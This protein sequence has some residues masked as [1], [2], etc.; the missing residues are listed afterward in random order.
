ML[1]DVMDQ[2][3][4][5][6][7]WKK[8]AYWSFPRGKINKDEKDLDCAIRE[9]YEETGFDIK[10]ADL[11][12]REEE[13]KFIEVTMREQH[14]RLY[15]FRGVPV[16]TY[17]EPRTRKEISKIQWYKLSEL[18]TLT[19]QKQQQEGR[20]EDL[21]VNANKFYMVA[22]FLGP[23]KKWIAQQSKQDALKG[24]DEYSPPTEIA[25]EPTLEEPLAPG[26]HSEPPVAGD[27]DRLLAHLRQSS[28]RQAPSNLPELSGFNGSSNEASLQLKRLL[29]VK[30]A[31]PPANT[32]VIQVHDDARDQDV[33]KSK[34]LLA[35]LRGEATTKVM[36]Q[37]QGKEAPQTPLEQIKADTTLSESPHQHHPRP[38]Q[39]SSLPP[40]PSFASTPHRID[41][42]YVA[43]SREQGTKSYDAN[44]PE[45]SNHGHKSSA[46]PSNMAS[47]FSDIRMRVPRT[48]QT[49]TDL[50]FH[51]PAI[52]PLSQKQQD[53]PAPY[54]R[55]GD[56]RYVQTSQFSNLHAPSIPPANKLPLPKLNS[57]SLALL[58]TFRNGKVKEPITAQGSFSAAAPPDATLNTNSNGQNG[59]YS[60]Q[61]LPDLKSIGDNVTSVAPLKIHQVQRQ[62]LD[63]SPSMN[64]SLNPNRDGRKT[65]EDHRSGQDIATSS[66]TAG[67]ENATLI[68]A[69]N[70]SVLDDKP[71]TVHQAALLDL[72]RKPSVVQP[73]LPKVSSHIPRE[74]PA[75]AELSAQASMKPKIEK[76]RRHDASTAR[77]PTNSRAGTSLMPGSVNRK[78]ASPK[79]PVSATVSGPLDIPQ[80]DA[81]QKRAD[82]TPAETKS[83]I[84][85]G[86][87]LRHGQRVSPVSILR[88]PDSKQRVSQETKVKERDGPSASPRGASGHR[89]KPSSEGLPKPFLPQILRRPVQPSQQPPSTA[90][91]P[92]AMS[93]HR[94]SFDRGDSQPKEQKQT[95][96][97][98]FG[99]PA[100]ATPP[101]LSASSA[102][103]SPI[104]AKP[105]HADGMRDE[106]ARS[107]IGSVS[108]LI[109][110]GIAR[111]GSGR[112]T[113]ITPN[114]RSFLLG[115]LESVAK[116]ER[117]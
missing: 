55:T 97:S 35:L 18:P 15:V 11:V 111:S 60:V 1:N 19:R 40:P 100:I 8:G 80:F 52:G 23:L 62:D 34:S 99:K 74:S 101:R 106:I 7:G 53:I 43:H 21:A 58:D 82:I 25:G 102:V 24:L 72:F 83:A 45:N 77:P 48:P 16:D 56:P 5:V 30:E 54:Q 91:P 20:G 39:F 57:H 95:L 66:R 29:S 89:N 51:G 71:P 86:T 81:V 33:A 78:P 76:P 103:V 114:E 17:F 37:L 115:Y 61:E 68:S 67:T 105:P 117:N 69:R 50:A 47:Q 92:A 84:P 2:V 4:L 113:P 42:Q 14:M 6:K 94:L 13:M 32:P 41:Q 44:L 28:Q 26:N 116:G 93:Q 98:L 108:S 27:M 112:Q 70:P 65:K 46:Q 22:P 59:E 109:G 3:V 107:R 90:S 31:S 63:S 85:N 79:P 64:P 75:P 36:G 9:V 49:F 10:E 12:G 73:E 96:L 38:P 88:R 110:D 104:Q 87:V